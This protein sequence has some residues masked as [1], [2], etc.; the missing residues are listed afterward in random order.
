[1]AIKVLPSD[2]LLDPT[3]TDRFRRE[4]KVLAKLENLHIIP[5]YDFGIGNR[6]PWIAEML[7]EGCTVSSLLRSARL[8]LSRA[9]SIICQVAAA[10]EYA[11][12]KGVIHLDVKP[13]NILLDGSGN[14][15]LTDFGIAWMVQGSTVLARTGMIVGTP[16]YMAPELA[17][18]K[19]PDHRCD[20]CALRVV[21]YEMLTGRVPFTADTPAAIL[22]KHLAEP[23][24]V[25]SPE[26]VPEKLTRVVLKSL[27]KEPG[28]RWDSAKEFGRS[29]ERACSW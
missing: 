9:V 19:E 16:Q 1:V 8:Y 25:P 2:F 17:S 12:G 11:H 6:I 3:F 21:A 28:D 24:P 26:D 7:V 13:Q 14:V 23:I 5:I 27:A 15:Y 22:M 20:V 18:E 10:L 4:A 29:L